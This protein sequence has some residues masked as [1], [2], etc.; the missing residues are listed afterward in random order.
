MDAPS[1]KELKTWIHFSQ[2]M[3]LY[4]T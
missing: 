2:Q 4:Y 1:V 3:A